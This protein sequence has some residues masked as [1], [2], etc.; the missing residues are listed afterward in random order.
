MYAGGLFR[1]YGLKNLVDGFMAYQNDEARLWIF[2]SGDYS[3]DIRQAS[4]KDPRIEYGGVI[5]LHEAERKEQEASLLINPRPA[6]QEFAKYSYPCKNLEYMASGTPLLTTK[7]PG[8][9]KECY[10]YVYMLDADTPE[11]ITSALEKIF[12]RP[13]DELQQKGEAARD[14]MLREKNNVAQAGRI[15]KLLEGIARTHG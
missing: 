6:A 14:L 3:D 13:K 1:Q 8:M 4:E 15:L 11:A 2:G 7:L 12:A 9:P 10:D 5:P